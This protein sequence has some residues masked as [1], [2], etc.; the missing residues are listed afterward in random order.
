MLKA[1]HK[2]NTNKA[3]LCLELQ[4]SIF[5]FQ[6][7]I[8]THIDCVNNSKLVFGAFSKQ[9]QGALKVCCA[10]FSVRLTSN[11]KYPLIF[12]LVSCCSCVNNIGSS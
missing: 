10:L 12:P 6:L 3:S 8:N 11:K 9:Q 4:M 7:A 1:K 5:F 2:Q